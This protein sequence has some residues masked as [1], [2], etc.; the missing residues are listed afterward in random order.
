MKIER[1]T[2]PLP[3]PAEILAHLNRTS[4]VNGLVGFLFATTGPLAILLTVSK[5]GGLSQVEISSWIFSGYGIGGLLSIL[6]S[7]LYRQPLGMAWTIP[8]AILLG[9][10]L[11]H[12]GFPEVIGAYLVTAVLLT[13][14][15]LTGWVSKGMEAMPMPLVMGMVSGVFLPFCLNIIFA[16]Q[17]ALWISLPM[18]A[19]FVAILAFPTLARMFSPVLGALIA[20]VV[21]TLLT[22][23]VEMDQPF[24]FSIGYP[25]FYVP[26]FSTGAL[27][28]LVVPLAVSVVGI[29]NAQGFA[30]LKGAGYEP[31]VNT[32]TVA[33]GVGSFFFGIFGSVPACVTG[34]VSAILNSSGPK[35]RRYVGGLVF[36]LCIFLFGLF[37]PVTAQLGLVLPTAFI[38]TLGGLAIVP[39]LQNSLSAAFGSRFSLGAFV[40]FLVTISEVTILN[41]GSAFWGLVF[42]FAASLLLEKGDF[43]RR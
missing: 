5:G 18:V 12:L 40:C 28:E 16:F 15:G 37:A 38:G 9:P 30:V 8:G 35:D 10:A 39:V 27:L 4:V 42:G 43:G 20:G 2:S 6:F 24:S 23:G 26:T 13:G 3:R 29:H 1:P 17:E 14:L 34:P 21:A 31:P 19:A 22:G 36:G 41:I 25:H 11:N 7:L 32:L 33:C